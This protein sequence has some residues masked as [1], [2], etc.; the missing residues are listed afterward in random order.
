MLIM[1]NACNEVLCLVNLDP[2]S[3]KIFG[4]SEFLAGLALM[5]LA[6]TI[7]DTRYRFRVKTAPVPL[8]KITFWVVLFVGI[9]SLMTDL[10]RANGFPVIKGN[11][12]SSVT[13]QALLAG[14]YFLTFISW[15]WFAFIRP[16][17][18]S[19]MTYRRYIETVYNYILKGSKSELAIVSDELSRSTDKIILYATS[20]PL[21]FRDRRDIKDIPMIERAANEILGLISDKRFCQAVIESSQ[22]FVLYLF[23]DIESKNKY[24]VNIRIFSKNITTEALRYN[25]SFLYHESSH[26]ESGIIGK[27]K[28]LSSAIFGKFDLVENIGTAFD[29]DYE[30]E[31]TWSDKELKA[32]VGAFSLFVEDYFGKKNYSH[33]YVFSRTIDRIVQHSSQLYTLNGLDNIWQSDSARKLKVITKFFETAI[34][35]LNARDTQFNYNLRIRGDDLGFSSCIYDSLSNAMFDVIHNASYIS[36]PLYS[37]WSIHHNSVFNS[38]FLSPKETGEASKI[39]QHKLRR[40][41]YNEIIRLNT[42]PNFKGARILGFCLSTLG[43]KPSEKRTSRNTYALHKAV[44]SWVRRNYNSLQKINSNVSDACLFDSIS[45]DKSNNRLVKVYEANGITQ[46]NKYIYLDLD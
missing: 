34:Q 36:K 41:I 30:L 7:A 2:N 27:I 35:K 3:P 13:W 42:S 10:W 23:L 46:V 5:V 15:V 24:N 32:Y 43:L 17:K 39:I 38:F 31:Q 25:D 4:F 1:I 16:S 28:P 45:Y 18:F 29:I 22:T 21:K 44:L 33:S 12:I 19:K 6:W 8:E 9:L 20:L 14:V 37:M 26:Y 11:L 40:L